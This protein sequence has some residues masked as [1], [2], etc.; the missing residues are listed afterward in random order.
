MKTSVLKSMVGFTG[1][2][3]SLLA[4]PL[5]STLAVT[6]ILY[7][8][9]QFIDPQT[10]WAGLE[11]GNSGKTDHYCELNR[12]D[13][14]LRQ[15]SNSWSNMF[16]FFFGMVALNLGLADRK[17]N[18]AENIMLANPALSIWYG[19]TSIF[20]CAGSFFFHASLTRTGQHWDMTGTYAV[21]VLPV[22][23]N[24]VRLT[25]PRREN[26]KKA[27]MAII[28]I[29]LGVYVLFHV[30]KWVID[31]SVVIPLLAGLILFTTILYHRLAKT[32]V[33]ALLLA[34]AFGSLVF[35]FIVRTMDVNKIMC[36]PEGIYQGHSLW[37]FLA[38]LSVLLIYFVLRAE[39]LSE[40]RLNRLND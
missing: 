34:A 27:G 7:I 24:A 18:I 1:T 17:R 23:I 38:G 10:A 14:L 28:P 4:L 25:F 12:M 33:P 39:K 21:T 11:L 6:V 16:Y 13:E 26:W 22:V 8:A 40:P 37:H 31:S 32:K 36:D 20:L 3:R 2:W 9:F 30:F 29:S 15:P 35:A 19:L 5:L